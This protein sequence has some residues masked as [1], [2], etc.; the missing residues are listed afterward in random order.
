MK[1]T[2]TL[3]LLTC[4]SAC[5][6]C[7]AQS[8]VPRAD[9]AAATTAV[10]S[11]AVTVKSAPLQVSSAPIRLTFAPPRTTA[12]PASAPEVAQVTV[13]GYQRV[14][15]N[16]EERFCRNDVATGSHTEHN[17]KCLTQAQ[18][19]EE[20]ARAQTFMENVQRQAGLA[21]KPYNVG[22]LVR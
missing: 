16:G 2:A 20:Q 17:F 9:T 11:D 6:L 1:S 18:L 21:M 14:I 19:K 3:F 7:A 22:G 4:T 15:I 12:T 8:P 13:R 5:V 10:G